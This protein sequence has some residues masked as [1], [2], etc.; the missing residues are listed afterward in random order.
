MRIADSTDDDRLKFY[1]RELARVQP[2]TSDEGTELLKQRQLDGKQAEHA[3]KRLIE[4]NLSLVVVIAEEFF[5]PKCPTLD[6]IEKGNL[7]LLL[8]VENFSGESG[9]EFVV[10]AAKR[11]QSALSKTA[12][13]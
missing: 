11:I 10:Y 4:A 8:A 5:S 6:L 2:L 3:K 12:T 9:D 1:L 7:G 13:E